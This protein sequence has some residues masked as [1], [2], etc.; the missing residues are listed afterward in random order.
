MICE[1]KDLRGLH[2]PIRTMSCRV[3]AP[4][5]EVVSFPVCPPPETKRD[6]SRLDPQLKAWLDETRGTFDD[7]ALHLR[8][9]HRQRVSQL[10]SA[11]AAA[12]RDLW[13]PFTQHQSVRGSPCIQ[14]LL[15]VTLSVL[16]Y[17]VLIALRHFLYNTNSSVNIFLCDKTF[18]CDT[19]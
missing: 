7:V 17:D 9:W 6:K 19:D 13:W 2:H 8:Q 10:S 15:A 11:A 18:C 4:P 3:G 16:L 14:F 1:A 12:R 5:V